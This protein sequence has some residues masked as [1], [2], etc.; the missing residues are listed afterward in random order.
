MITRHEKFRLPDVNNQ[1]DWFIEVNWNKK[2]KKT[3]ECKVVKVTH[4]DGSE[5]LLKREQL[6][7]VLFAI[8]N[9][10]E[11]REMVPQ[12]QKITRVYETTISVKAKKRVE[13][14]EE[15]T[16]PLRL[17]LPEKNQDIIGQAPKKDHIIGQG[18]RLIRK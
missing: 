6:H 4:P 18:Q 2:D 3:N 5:S 12:S 16:F 1:N 17:T 14:G 8:G 15:I 11:Q 13:K 10:A 9:A 7:S